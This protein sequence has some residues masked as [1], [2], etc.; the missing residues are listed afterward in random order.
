MFSFSVTFWLCVNFCLPG[1]T[2][3]VF[4]CH[5]RHNYTEHFEWSVTPEQVCMYTMIHSVFN[6]WYMTALIHPY[7]SCICWVLILPTYWVRDNSRYVSATMSWH[8]Q[9]Q[10]VHYTSVFFFSDP[11]LLVHNTHPCSI[12]H[13]CVKHSMFHILQLLC[14]GYMTLKFSH[15]FCFLWRWGNKCNNIS[16]YLGVNSSVYLQKWP[17]D[18]VIWYFLYI[19]SVLTRT[20]SLYHVAFIHFMITGIDI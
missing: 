2:T 10:D 1:W 18:T 15:L 6:T 5:K 11:G 16:H 17:F 4:W 19:W 3:G 7:H 9:S 13:R 14:P 20:G 12:L 8:L